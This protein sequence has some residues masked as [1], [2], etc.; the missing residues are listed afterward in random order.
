MT[1]GTVQAEQSEII[2]IR[3]NNKMKI[4]GKE[5]VG[6][7]VA[8]EGCH[9]L[10][11]CED[12]QDELMMLSLGYKVYPIEML[13]ELYEHSCSLRFISNAKFDK[14]YVKQF[15]RAVFEEK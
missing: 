11:I 8:Y 10:Y 6:K 13:E 5:V 4:N 9:K 15:E 7:S 3:R 2:G 1:L 14:S 12:K